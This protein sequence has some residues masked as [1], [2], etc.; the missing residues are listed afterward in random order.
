MNTV[1][2]I[3]GFVLLNLVQPAI[4]ENNL[5]TFLYFD[6]FKNQ[7]SKGFHTKILKLQKKSIF[8]K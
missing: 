5:K 4:V 6:L 3:L 1:I 8:S 2:H 7:K